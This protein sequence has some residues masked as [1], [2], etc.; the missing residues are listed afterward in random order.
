MPRWCGVD[1][2]AC[3]SLTAVLS[4][5]YDGGRSSWNLIDF[6]VPDLLLPACCGLVTEPTVLDRLTCPLLPR[7]VLDRLTSPALLVFKEF[8][9]LTPFSSCVES[10]VPL[11]LL[12][13]GRC[14]N[15]KAVLLL[16]LP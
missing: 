15:E 13:A 4:D 16:L 12:A 3:L 8:D 14:S 9:R 6:S 7:R 11:L 2:P 10:T 5:S 1:V